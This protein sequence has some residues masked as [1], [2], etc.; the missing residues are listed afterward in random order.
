MNRPAALMEYSTYAEI[1]LGKKSSQTWARTGSSQPHASGKKC[2]GNGSSSSIFIP[3]HSTVEYQVV[4]EVDP[5]DL[6]PVD[7]RELV[8]WVVGHRVRESPL[9]GPY[10]PQGWKFP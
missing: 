7:L 9:S 6:A 10:L 3:G 4:F 2:T 1:V 5:E 8:T